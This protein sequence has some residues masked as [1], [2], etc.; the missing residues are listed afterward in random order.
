MSRT[1]RS[2]RA[3]ASAIPA[4]PDQAPDAEPRAASLWAALVYAV[5]TLTLGFPALLGR[6]LVSP[7]SDQYI[8]GYAVREF[9]T[10]VLHATGHWPLWNPYLFG[11]M[12]FVGAMNGDIFYPTFLLRLALPADVAVTWAFVIHIFLAGWLTYLFLRATG[13]GFWGGLIGG[14]AYMMGGP[15]ASYVSPGHDGKLYVSAL[16]PLVLLLLLRGMR[17][18]R[19]TAWPLLALTI[20]LGI[21]S[22]HPQIMQYLLLASGAYA[23]YLAFWSGAEIAQDR[24]TAVRRLGAAVAAVAVGLAMGAV[25]FLP[26]A[27]YV[28]SSPRAG[29]GHAGYTAYQFSASYS[30]PIEEL[31]NTYLPQFTGLLDNYWGR[32]GIHFHSEYL[33]ALVLV[34]AGCAFVATKPE[35]LHGIRFWLALAIVGTLW[36]LG[37]YTPFFRLPFTLIPGTSYFRAPAAIFFLTGFAVAALVGEGVETV[38]RGAVGRRYVAI[39]AAVAAAIALL[40]V[41]GGLTTMG[42][43]IA[44]SFADSDGVARVADNAAAVMAGAVR[45]FA[46]VLLGGS[47][48]VLAHRRTW[49]PRRLGIALAVLV[50]ADLWSIER[51]YWNFLPSAAA[52]YGSDAAIDYV[53][54]QTEPGRVLTLPT[55]NT[56]AHDP[57]LEG[58]A[59]MVHRVR[60]VLG[61]HGNEIKRWDDLLGKTEGY[62]KAYS[63]LTWRLVNARFLLT[64][65]APDSMPIP[66]TQRLAGPVTDAAGSTVYLYRLP[67]DNPAAWVTPVSV[68]APD[69]QALATVA[70]PRFDPVRAAIFDTSAHDVAAQQVS[71][72]PPAAGITAAATRYDPGHLAFTLSG[73]APAGA[74]LIVSENYYAGWVATVDGHPAPVGRADYTLIGVPLPA[75]ATK[76]ELDFHSSVVTLG[77]G[78]TLAA[79]AVA[80]LWLVAQWMADRRSAVTAGARPVI[81]AS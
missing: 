31:F 51:L 54:H 79:A 43:G 4:L 66:G 72:L 29:G 17:D 53:A 34:L 2:G 49:S 60:S 70:D 58:D 46:F 20:G 40:G 61:Y 81:D 68:K 19:R 45:S 76:V 25:Q 18:G 78:I 64:D 12:P 56:V 80:L 11:G 47:V 44:S 62:R 35:R 6:F 16:F 5:A 38:L 27:Q 75:G 33:G 42:E 36:S 22:P 3:R 63:A 14:L 77:A 65:L 1:P 48:I 52:A 69:A 9:G 73:P 71:T 28:A 21:L 74:A 8:G 13:L 37:G 26:V 55:S 7:I 67:G 10:S 50:A 59:L 23:L 24:R 39:W 15:I 30:M 32:T 41:T 57:E